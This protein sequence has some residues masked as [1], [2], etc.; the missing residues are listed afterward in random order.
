MGLPAALGD[1]GELARVG[2]LPEAHP[3]KPELAVDRV[4]PAAPLAAGVATHLELGLARGLVDECCLGHGQA[5]FVAIAV[6]GRRAAA[7]MMPGRGSR[8]GGAARVPR[9]RSWLSSRP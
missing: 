5:S 1:A 6:P 3:A 8:A 2:H 7:V 4:R 9:R